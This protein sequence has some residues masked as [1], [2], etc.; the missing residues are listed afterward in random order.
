MLTT[1]ASEWRA[2]VDWRAAGLKAAETRR[3]NLGAVAPPPAAPRQVT[4]GGRT[5]AAL[6][7]WATRRQLVG[8]ASP[9]VRIDDPAVRRQL[10]RM[11][12]SMRE[13]PF[14]SY[15]VSH[16]E[17]HGCETGHT[18]RVAGDPIF[19]TIGEVAGEWATRAETDEAIAAV[20]DG[21]RPRVRPGLQ[22]LAQAAVWTA[23][24]IAAAQ[25]AVESPITGRVRI[26]GPLLPDDPQCFNET[27][28]EGSA[29]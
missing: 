11:L 28:E 9:V 2:R 23:Q 5:A 15:W 14:D 8:Q 7:A 22:V 24:A 3:R 10:R 6:K 20:L 13:F 16:G 27:T 1:P 18:K 21:R 29:A 19:H 4:S 12:A 17:R 26:R 25:F